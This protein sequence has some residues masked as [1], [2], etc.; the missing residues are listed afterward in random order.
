MLPARDRRA[1]TPAASRESRRSSPGRTVAP[2]SRRRSEY[3]W[4][5][6]PCRRRSRRAAGR[7]S[8]ANPPRDARAPA[9]WRSRGCAR[10][11]SESRN[12]PRRIFA[13]ARGARVFHSLSEYLRRAAPG[14]CQA[15]AE[16]RL[17]PDDDPLEARG[18]SQSE[19]TTPEFLRASKL[20]RVAMRVAEVAQHLG[21]QED[22]F[23]KVAQRERAL[24][25]VDRMR[26]STVAAARD[27]P[28]Q[29]QCRRP[30]RVVA[31]LLRNAVCAGRGR[32]RLFQLPQRNEEGC[33]VFLDERL[34]C[35]VVRQIR[36]LQRPIEDVG[37]AG[38]C[39]F[40]GIQQTEVVEHPQCGVRLFLHLECGKG[41]PEVGDRLI[42]AS[43]D[44]SDYSQI[45]LHHAGETAVTQ[46]VGHA[47]RFSVPTLR[48]G[49]IA[50][51]LGDGTKTVQGVRAPRAV[52]DLVR[53]RQTLRV[54]VRRCRMI[55]TI[56]Q[57][58]PLPPKNVRQ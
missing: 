15:G 7:W 32:F 18:T 50:T 36:E 39:S 20:A 5:T 53:D 45:L 28:E 14:V 47:R 37:G 25:Q 22:V 21:A 10:R 56:A 34:G 33:A 43:L 4:R 27:L 29:T 49:E 12:P 23:A 11:C 58:R 38:V 26:R 44:V 46:P 54:Q 40:P 13:K 24:E 52:R 31:P 3:P 30:A 8:A 1:R 41:E 9:P 57:Y 48:G 51:K 55:S 35:D 42:G 16:A 19:G 2:S 17:Q 6:I